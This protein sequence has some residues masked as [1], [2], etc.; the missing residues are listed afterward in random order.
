[1]LFCRI[2]STPRAI[3]SFFPQDQSWGSLSYVRPER[4]TALSRSPH[5]RPQPARPDLANSTSN[6]TG[7]TRW[8]LALSANSKFDLESIQ[9]GGLRRRPKWA[10]NRDP[11]PSHGGLRMRPN[12]DPRPSHG[13]L[14][15]LSESDLPW[16]TFGPLTPRP[17]PRTPTA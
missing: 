13:G 12:R 4:K 2:W 9:N 7:S 1:M 10:P 11:R 6:D 17:G 14:R 5:S 16:T 3:V 15:M 8:C